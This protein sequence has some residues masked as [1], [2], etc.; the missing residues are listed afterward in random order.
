MH[1]AIEKYLAQLNKWRE[2]TVALDEACRHC[3]AAIK[4]KPP[5]DDASRIP[6]RIRVNGM[7]I[8]VELRVE[9]FAQAVPV[10]RAIRKAGYK[11]LSNGQNH[12]EMRRRYWTFAGKIIVDATLP[13]SDDAT[14]RRVQVGTK[15]EPVYEWHCD[16]GSDADE[17]VLDETSEPAASE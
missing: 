13:A 7:G 10:L 16:D 3:E 1:P 14:C 9:S 12:F 11:M 8:W 6:D 5:N 15:E 4:L 17:D 2:Q